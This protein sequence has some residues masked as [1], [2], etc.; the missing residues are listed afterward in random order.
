[1]FALLILISFRGHCTVSSK[2]KVFVEGNVTDFNYIRNNISFVDFINDAYSSDVHVIVTRKSTGSGGKHYYILFNSNTINSI[3]EFELN[4]ITNFQDSRDDIRYK[5]TEC[6]KSGLL[7]C[8]NEKQLF[9]TVNVNTNGY[10]ADSQNPVSTENHDY[11]NNWVF[12]IGLNGGFNAE[13]R[14][15]NYEYETFFEA[16]RITE[17]WRIRN[18][19]T[20]SREETSIEKNKDLETYT[21]HAYNQEHEM[22]SRTVYSL[23]SHWSVGC[24]VEGQQNTYRN[25]EFNAAFQAA[26]EYNIYPWKMVDR[27]ILTIGYYIGPSYYNYF[28]PTIFEKTSENLFSHSL[29]IELDKVEKWGEIEVNLEAGHY[30]SNPKYY[31]L[32][33]GVELSFKVA[34][35]LF[36]EFGLEAEKI[37]NQLYLPASDLSDEELLLDVRKLPTSF[38]LSGDIGIRYQFGSIY[39]NVVN[40]RL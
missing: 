31:A 1:M 12:N 9:Y 24:F 29:K 36:F 37:N 28:E 25:I 19:Y 6:L 4:C 15:K 21:I 34:R 38:E 14:R 16:N 27:H 2:L 5:L 33:S 23:S 30:L 8:S 22:E 7:V 20:F 3:D 10:I 26:I 17:K 39:N 35:G 13:E 40:Q 32:E 18:Q 11:W